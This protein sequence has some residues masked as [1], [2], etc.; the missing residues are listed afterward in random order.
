V[1]DTLFEHQTIS[2]DHLE[3]VIRERGAS[4]DGSDTG[5]GKTHTACDVA[6]KLNRATL[7][8]VPKIAISN[9]KETADHLDTELDVLNW[10]MLRTGRTPYGKWDNPLTA[11]RRKYRCPRCLEILE[12]EELESPC[13]CSLT[14]NHSDAE[15]IAKHNYGKFTWHDAIEFLIMDEVHRANGIKSL[16]AEMLVAAKRQGIPTLALSATPACSPLHFRGLGYLLG[17]HQLTGEAGFY[18]WSKGLGCRRHPQ[19][20]GWIW[21]QSKADQR[22]TMANLSRIIFPRFGVRVRSDDIPGFP[23]RRIQANLFDLEGYKRIDELYE[24]MREAMLRLQARKA[25]DKDPTNPLTV[26]LRCRQELELLKVPPVVELVGDYLAKGYAVV[27][28]VNYSETLAELRKRLKCDCFI[29]GTQTGK[30]AVRQG[31]IDRFQSNTERV[32]I[33]NNQ[34]G[35]ESCSLHDIRGEFPCVGLVMPPQSARIFRQL[36]G[37]LPRM[38]GKSLALYRVIF[39]ANTKE[40]DIHKKLA[41]SLNNIDSLMDSDLVPNNLSDLI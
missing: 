33:V 38:N 31:H 36:A 41:Q 7:A 20:K 29:D 6:R 10:E 28:F 13:R 23:K 24:E 22:Q 14:L 26:M 35:G 21:A 30:P 17:M 3:D 19:F 32:I 15:P 34:A 39:A 25:E 4:L 11:E 2:S 12:F 1:S 9:W 5:V 16:N 40:V 8:I 18:A 37:R 27:V